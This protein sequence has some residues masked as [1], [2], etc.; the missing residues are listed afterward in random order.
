VASKPVEYGRLVAGWVRN[1]ALAPRYARHERMWLRTADGVRLAAARLAGPPDAALTVVLAHGFLHSCRTPRVHAFARMLAA[2]ANVVVPDLRGHGASG[3]VTTLGTFEPLDVDAAVRAADPSLPVV[4]V[5]MSLGAAAV[6]RH[7]GILG[8][9]AGVVA[10]SAP[11]R[12]GTVD[13]AGAERMHRF[14]ESRAGRRLAAGLLRTRIPGVRDGFPEAREAAAC[15]APA[16]LIVVHDPADDY[17][18]EEHA[19]ALY[20]S[21]REPKELWLV[22]G[23]GHG[24][25][26]LTQAMADRVLDAVTTRLR[27]LSR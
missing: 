5:G 17:F 10:I 1:Y 14:V 25:D 24:S 18:G 15:I 12:W 21:A 23:A 16:F 8:G 13:R 20:E 19:Q 4:T 11:A 3:G 27:A 26:L 6:V 22:P 9:V 7:A 2:R